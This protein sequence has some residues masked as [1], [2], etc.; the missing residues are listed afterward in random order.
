MEGQA[1]MSIARDKYSQSETP[2]VRTCRLACLISPEKFKNGATPCLQWTPARIETDQTVVLDVLVPMSIERKQIWSAQ[3]TESLQSHVR[4]DLINETT[5]TIT[6]KKY[7][8]L[9][10]LIDRWRLCRS[11]TVN[12]QH[13]KKHWK[14]LSRA[15]LFWWDNSEFAN[16][17]DRDIIPFQYFTKSVMWNSILSDQLRSETNTESWFLG[18]RWIHF[19]HSNCLGWKH[20]D[21]MQRSLFDDQR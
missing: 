5:K 11:T 1:K 21:E 20:Y 16:S 10:E 17:C 15:V 7:N 18:L 2:S 4:G 9:L 6:Q 13:P 3:R 19:Q 14:K 8:F 12:H